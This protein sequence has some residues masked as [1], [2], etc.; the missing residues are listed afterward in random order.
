MMRVAL[1]LEYN[2]A[3]YYGW[4]SQKADVLA[5]QDVVEAAVSSV[6]NEPTQVVCAGRTDRGVHAM[7]QVVHFDTEVERSERS[8]LL[9]T[10]SNLPHDV[11][12]Q[13][14]RFID[15]DFHARFSAVAREYLYFIDNSPTRPGL[16]NQHVTW[17]LQP[18]DEQKM[19]K[20]MQ[21]LQGKHDFSSF[22][23]ADCQAKSPV[24]TMLAPELRRQGNII[25]MRFRANA[26]LHHMIRNI[27]GTLFAI[28]ESKQPVAWM[29]D[30][31][32][33]K[34]RRQAGVTAPPHGLYLSSVQYPDK[35]AISNESRWGGFIEGA[36]CFL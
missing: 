20:A 15:D 16:F 11:A 18:L 28:G 33:A 4:Q 1:G 6:A 36:R 29:S 12:I 17:H 10:N 14:A 35:Y 31:L 9:G 19:W 21:L 26:F 24:R 34:D 22:R 3:A 30:V 27:V 2:G 13:W 25:V 32:Q 23:C 7:S 8:W 5:V